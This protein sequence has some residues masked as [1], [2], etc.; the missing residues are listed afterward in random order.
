MVRNERHFK[1]FNLD[2]GK[3]IE[4]DFVLFLIQEKP[5]KSF[6]YQVFIEPKGSH[7]LKTDE[8]KEKF[9]QRLRKEHKIEQL[10]K[11]KEYIIWGMPFYNEV[12]QKG[13]FE[14]EFMKLHNTLE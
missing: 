6:H 11:G 7:L 14:E 13:S 2:D 8:W 1:I 9:L 4:P 12:E 5:S 10:W 3:P